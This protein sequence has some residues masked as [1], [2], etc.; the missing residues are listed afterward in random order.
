MAKLDQIDEKLKLSE[1]DRNVIKKEMRHNKHEYLD[2]YFH[3]AKATEEK[4]QKMSDK[5][6]STDEEREKNIRKERHAGN[7]AAI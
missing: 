5:V 7:E 6:E 1:E 2:N 3:L 4:L